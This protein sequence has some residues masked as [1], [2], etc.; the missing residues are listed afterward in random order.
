MNTPLTAQEQ[1]EFNAG[2]E[3][4]YKGEPFPAQSSKAT[5]DGYSSVTGSGV[6]PGARTPNGQAEFDAGAKLARE[7]KP[8]P[9]HSTPE[10]REGFASGHT[11]GPSGGPAAPKPPEPKILVSHKTPVKAQTDRPEFAPHVW[12]EEPVNPNENVKITVVEQGKQYTVEG[13]GSGTKI[14][15]ADVTEEALIAIVIDR[16]EGDT[17]YN[18][19][20]ENVVADL[21][22]ALNWLQQ[23]TQNRLAEAHDRRTG[24][25]GFGGRIM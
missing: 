18:L 5:Q 7:G 22:K 4:A 16:N 1:I 25:A 15:F 24:V 17:S 13:L 23:R 12:K 14:N 8:L 9:D 19:Y 21:K 10:K 11:A 3:S 6:T 20:S 2:K